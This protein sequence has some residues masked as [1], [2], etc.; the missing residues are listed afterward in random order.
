MKRKR[1]FDIKT[2]A[3]AMGAVIFP[4][5]FITVGDDVERPAADDI[6]SPTLGV[7]TLQFNGKLI[8][9]ATDQA[10]RR[11][12]FQ[13][14][15]LISEV[16]GQPVK[17]VSEF[18]RA[19]ENKKKLDRVRVLLTRDESAVSIKRKFRG[20]V[21]GDNGELVADDSIERVGNYA[22]VKPRKKK[23]VAAKPKKRRKTK[24]VARVKSTDK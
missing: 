4:L 15:D 13:V 5:L 7:N 21:R 23:K 20:E 2:F 24:T 8:V 10:G 14:G 22:R 16:E 6:N 17:R 12:G 18:I 11:F 19:V 3:L 9:T 1:K